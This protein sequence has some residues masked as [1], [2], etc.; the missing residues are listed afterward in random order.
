MGRQW[1]IAQVAQ[2]FHVTP[3]AAAFE[4][5]NDPDDLAIQCLMLLNYAD[6]WRVW[7]KGD[8]KE[9]AAYGGSFAMKMV[10]QINMERME[11]EIREQEEGALPAEPLPE[12]EP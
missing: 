3:G 7:K 8:K 1:L 10:E 5:D 11:A 2:A 12:G 4:M 9:I 6:A